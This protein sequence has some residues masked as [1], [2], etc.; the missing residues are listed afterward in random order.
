VKSLREEQANNEK[1]LETLG[2]GYY[3]TAVA[4]DT[5]IA[6]DPEILPLV[7]EYIAASAKH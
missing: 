4:L 3:F 7:E 5:H 6:D 2:N 1:L